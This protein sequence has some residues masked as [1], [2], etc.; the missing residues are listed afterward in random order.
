MESEM[1]DLLK[2]LPADRSG[3]RRTFWLYQAHALLDGKRL[4]KHPSLMPARSISTTSAPAL[5]STSH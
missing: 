3:W 2:I 1:S 4:I 5:L